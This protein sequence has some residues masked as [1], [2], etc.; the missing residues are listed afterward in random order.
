MGEATAALAL[1]SGYKEVVSTEKRHTVKGLGWLKEGVS[2]PLKLA[3]FDNGEQCFLGSTIGA[4]KNIA[5]LA[6]DLGHDSASAQRSFYQQLPEFL[7][8]RGCSRNIFTLKCPNTEG[9]TVFYAKANRDKHRTYFIW[10]GNIEGIPV[11]IRVGSVRK[12][13][14]KQLLRILATNVG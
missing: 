13:S 8:T 3:T 5:R 6:A 1:P 11:I 2:V 14:E 7:E 4:D 9:K 10:D 12:T